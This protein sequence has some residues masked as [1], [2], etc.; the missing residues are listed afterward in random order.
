MPPTGLHEKLLFLARTTEVHI[1]F[2][3][4]ILWLWAWDIV[5]YTEREW[6]S[7]QYYFIDD[8]LTILCI[9]WEGP[10]TLYLE[11]L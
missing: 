7:T 2:C 10:V 3:S 6:G 1:V 4:L 5:I 8:A 11:C 9:W